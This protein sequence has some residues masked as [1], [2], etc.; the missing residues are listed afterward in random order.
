MLL[1]LPMQAGTMIVRLCP[2]TGAGAAN[3]QLDIRAT[4]SC[5][6]CLTIGGAI[7]IDQDAQRST[8]QIVKLTAFQRPEKGTEAQQAQAECDRNQ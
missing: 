7:I 4:R 5:E 3:A 6:P 8:V 1:L 2:S